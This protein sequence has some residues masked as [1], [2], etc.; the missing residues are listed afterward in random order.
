MALGLVCIKVCKEFSLKSLIGQLGD[1]TPLNTGSIIEDRQKVRALH[2]KL[3]APQVRTKD[4]GRMAMIL[5]PG[6]GLNKAM[7]ISKIPDRY[8]LHLLRE[9]DERECSSLKHEIG[10]I[11]DLVSYIANASLACNGSFVRLQERK[12]KKTPLVHLH[13][14]IFFFKAHARMPC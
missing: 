6:Y 12:K 9:P 14:F 13:E 8:E 4:K 7:G 1:T 10:N 3:E 2:I 5:P 11:F